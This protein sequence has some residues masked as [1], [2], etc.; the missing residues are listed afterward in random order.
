MRVRM[1]TTAR[2]P[3][4]SADV[5]QEVEVTEDLALELAEAGSAELLPDP[6]SPKIVETADAPPAVSTAVAPEG[7]RRKR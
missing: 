1:K 5:G 6:P 7:R 3:G 4:F 2:G